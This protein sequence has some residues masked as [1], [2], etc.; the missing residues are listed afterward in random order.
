MLTDS[1]LGHSYIFHWLDF[2]VEGDTD[3]SRYLWILC[4]FTFS[5]EL[6]AEV[7]SKLHLDQDYSC[8]VVG[9]WNTWYG[10]QDQAGK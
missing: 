4:L 6:R 1:S 8:E 10:D 3:I 5:C 2:T 9:S 7:Q